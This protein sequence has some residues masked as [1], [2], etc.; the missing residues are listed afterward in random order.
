[1]AALVYAHVN[2]KSIDFSADVIQLLAGV[3]SGWWLRPE[4][5][6]EYIIKAAAWIE[7]DADAAGYLSEAERFTIEGW[8]A[9]QAEA[10]WYTLTKEALQCLHPVLREWQE[11]RSISLSFERMHNALFTTLDE[12][13]LHQ[14]LVTQGKPRLFERLDTWLR[15]VR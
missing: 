1:M 12:L 11:Q 13:D 6:R 15:S 7:I 9:R 2:N 3:H 10:G 8:I 14:V 5:V 4:A